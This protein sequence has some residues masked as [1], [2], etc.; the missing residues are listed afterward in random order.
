MKQHIIFD[1]ETTGLPIDYKA[2]AE[3]V[4][5]WPR[6]IQ[7]AYAVFDDGGNLIKQRCSLIKPEGWKVPAEK[8]W[9]DKGFSTEKN[10]AEGS[11]IADV[12]T[13]FIVERLFADYSIAHNISFDGKIIRAEMI[14]LGMATEFVS[15]KVCTMMKSTK[16]CNI[17]GTRGPKWPTLT[18]LHV[19]LFGEAFDNSHDA[20]ADVMACAK[21]Y[22]ELRKRGVIIS[23]NNATDKKL[24]DTAL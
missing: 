12:L 21:C 6:V 3:Q 13:D 7:L 15:E 24:N 11:P 9:I 18:E 5:N 22:F 4:D 10:E 14:R 16:Y 23:D 1:V 20:M 8:F 2:S 19:H 17:P